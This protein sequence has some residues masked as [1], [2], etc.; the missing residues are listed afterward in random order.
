MNIQQG[1]KWQGRTRE[2]GHHQPCLL[3]LDLHVKSYGGLMLPHKTAVMRLHTHTVYSLPIRTSGLK[4]L[5]GLWSDW[6]VA[7][8][9]LLSPTPTLA[10]GSNLYPT[11][12]SAA[13][14][15][16]SLI[17]IIHV[18]WSDLGSFDEH[19]YFSDES[20]IKPSFLD[21]VMS[22]SSFPFSASSA[23]FIGQYLYT[24]SATQCLSSH[25]PHLYNLTLPLPCYYIESIARDGVWVVPIVPVT[26]YESIIL[27]SG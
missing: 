3:W 16:Y 4:G 27:N 21:I 20:L 8:H 11:P 1:E 22:K 14:T 12:P 17:F 9:I 10:L 24:V 5:V 23:E 19:E 25:V 18:E 6:L 15:S 13:L 2:I 26:I 7:R